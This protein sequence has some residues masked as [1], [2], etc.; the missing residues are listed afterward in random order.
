MFGHG[1]RRPGSGRTKKI[2]TP[3]KKRYK[4]SVM[5]LRRRKARAQYFSVQQRLVDLIKCGDSRS[6]EYKSLEIEHNRLAVYLGLNRSTGQ[7]SG[8]TSDPALP[9]DV[10]SD[11]V[12]I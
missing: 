12:I 1:G 11:E 6:E 5:V 8:A 7:R 10:S 9:I 3:I 2:K 4:T